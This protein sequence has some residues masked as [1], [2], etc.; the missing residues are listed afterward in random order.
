LL[1]TS[2]TA[3]ALARYNCDLCGGTGVRP[4]PPECAIVPCACA[5]RRVFQACYRR[6]RQC[7][8]ADGSARRVSFA[9]SRRG[10]DRHLIWFR[11]NEDYCAD[12]QAAGRRSLSPELYRLFRFYHLLG[13]GA[14]LVARRLGVS[15]RELYRLLEEVETAVGREVAL[16]EPHSLYPPRHYLSRVVISRIA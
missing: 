3:G 12:F 9:E 13:G 8:E 16:M 7:A 4:S 14:D 5:C 15:R 1:W 6:F 11:R 2:E 10:V